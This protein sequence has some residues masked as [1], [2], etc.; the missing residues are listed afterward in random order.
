MTSSSGGDEPGADVSERWAAWRRDVDLDDYES[1]WARMAAAGQVVHGEADLIAS[2]GPGPVLDAGCGTGRVT[3]PV[4]AC[5]RFFSSLRSSQWNGT[6][7]R[8]RLLWKPPV[9]EMRS[10]GG[11]WNRY[12]S[13]T[14]R[15]RTLWESLRSKERPK[16]WRR[17][18]HAFEFA[19]GR[20]AVE[21]AIQTTA[22]LA[23]AHGKGIV[24][25]DLKPENVLIGPRGV[26]LID[27]G[28]AKQPA[29]A[30]LTQVGAVVG[31]VHYL[32][33]EQIR[34][35]AVDHRADIYSFG[36]V[37][38]EML[39]GG[40]PFIGER[41]AIEYQHTV[42]RP[43]SVREWRAVPDELHQLVTACLAKQPERRFQSAGDLAFALRAIR[44]R[45]VPPHSWPTTRRRSRWFADAPPTVP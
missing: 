2:L 30:G 1:R 23:A 33:P 35:A 37:A 21:I 45:A 43:P 17:I 28:L 22:A 27:F 36:V 18:E 42:C 4:A 29:G 15:H 32:A 26:R 3:I 24:H 6:K 40:P 13:A 7:A 10:C 44:S 25:R 11:K 41:R 14:H 39:C 8:E 20:E 19:E 31:T 34:G 9:A 16:G 5:W 38:F 12:S